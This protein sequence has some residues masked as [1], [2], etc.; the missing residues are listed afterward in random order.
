MRL[1]A[2]RQRLGLNQVEFSALGGLKRN[3]QS[4]YEAD[5]KFPDSRYLAGLAA[6]GVDVHFLFYGVYRNADKTPE[7]L[8]LEQAVQ[9]LP[10]AQQIVA[11]M[12]LR[13]LGQ[14]NTGNPAVVADWQR[15]AKLFE[16]F[17]A[18]GPVGRAAL[19]QAAIAA[20]VDGLAPA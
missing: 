8:A 15:A 14:A 17:L 19:E 11:L 13:L 20:K 18:A 3:S 9:A 10:P 1:L 6:G 12:V 16:Q 5:D 7:A 4:Q 2:E